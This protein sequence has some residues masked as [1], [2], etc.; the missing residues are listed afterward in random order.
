GE[1]R[2]LEQRIGARFERRGLEPE[3]SPCEI[4]VLARG[5]P[6][7]EA[8]HVGEEADTRSDRVT[9]TRDIMP[10]DV[11]RAGG[12]TCEVR[13]DARGRRLSVAVTP[14]E[15]Q[16]YTWRHDETN[17]VEKKRVTELLR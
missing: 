7:V 14:Q 4:E 16:H 10:E 17:V 1:H 9:H 5:H 13:K 15:A 11:R 8:R 12:G 3:E 2:H 6:R